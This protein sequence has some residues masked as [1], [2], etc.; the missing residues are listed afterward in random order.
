M[1]LILAACL[2]LITL[3][4]AAAD[5]P[6][7]GAE[8]E[9]Y[10]L[11]KTLTYA[12]EGQVFGTE[13]YLPGRKVIWAY[14]GQECQHGTWYEQADAICFVYET[15]PAAQCWRFFQGGAGLMAEF[16]GDPAGTAL[17]EVAQSQAPLF[18]PGP[19]IGA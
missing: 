13:Q 15:D 7:T 18:C 12:I 3:P 2:S 8:F 16:V 6:M 10:A 11:G 14:N 4:L 19:A 1:R 17:K 9:A 5:A